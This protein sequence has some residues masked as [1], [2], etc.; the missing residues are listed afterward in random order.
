M[1]VPQTAAL[2]QNPAQTIV[3]S[4]VLGSVVGV[5]AYVLSTVVSPAGNLGPMA[6]AWLFA[7]VGAIAGAVWGVARTAW[8]ARDHV[9]RLLPVW[10]LALWTATLLYTLIWIRLASQAVLPAIGLQVLIVAASAFVL[11]A[12][13]TR[14]KMPASTLRYGPVAVAA[15]ALIALMTAFPPVVYARWG[16][17]PLPTNPP[18]SFAFILDGRL[19]RAGTCLFLR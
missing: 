11:H 10:M 7:P 2:T 8:I 13:T 19:S 18:P 14:A 16:S 9:P 3:T 12:P 15:A 6:I 17:Q 5:G 1:G 4:T